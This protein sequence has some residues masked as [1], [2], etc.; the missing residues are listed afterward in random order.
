MKFPLPRNNWNSHIPL[1]PSGWAASRDFRCPKAIVDVSDQEYTTQIG[2][3]YLFNQLQALDKN[4]EFG[5]LSKSEAR[6]KCS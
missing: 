3:A 6:L 5:E 4:S 2:G 1:L